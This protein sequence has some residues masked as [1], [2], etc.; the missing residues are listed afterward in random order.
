MDKLTDILYRIKQLDGGQFQNLCDAYLCYLGYESFHPFGMCTGTN[1]TAPGSP[2]TY[3]FVT[4]HNKYVLVMYTAQNTDFVNKTLKDFEKC[5]D[6]E[7]TGLSSN[8]DIAEIVYCHTYER[9]KPGDHQKLYNF[10]A[11]RHVK[12][13]L[14]GIETIGMDIYTKYPR[15]AKMLGVSLDTDQ[16]HTMEE[17]VSM[18]DANTMSAP[19]KTELLFRKQEL[20]DAK[21]KLNDSNILL[22]TGP[23][24]T[25][26]TRFALQLCEELS[27][28]NGYSVLCIKN[29]GQPIYEDLI[30]SLDN[31]KHYLVFV[32]DANELTQLNLVLSYLSKPNCSQH[33]DKLVLTVRDY[34]R[35]K[36]LEQVLEVDKPEIIKLQPFKRDEITKIVKNSYQITNIQYLN[37]IADIAQG[38]PRLAMLAGKLAL[39]SNSL[40]VIHNVSELYAN[41]YG[42][43]IKAIIQSETGIISA[44]IIAFLQAL[45]LD[46]IDVLTSLFSIANITKDQFISDLK[47]LH[48]QELV[49]IVHDNGVR[50]SDESFSNY[51]IKYVFIDK[52]I[53]RLS[54]MVETCLG[55]N[56]QRTI[57]ACNI[58]LNVLF[59]DEDAKTYTLDELNCVW[60]N[61]EKDSNR[62]PLFFEKFYMI[63]PTQTLIILRNQINQTVPT[64]YDV[65]TIDLINSD[66]NVPISD[67]IITKLCN[68]SDEPEVSTAIDLMLQYYQKRPDLFLQI[69]S[70]I[71]QYFNVNIHAQALNYFTQQAVIERLCHLIAQSPPYENA[72]LFVQ[73]ASS[74]LQFDIMSHESYDDRSIHCYTIHLQMNKT[75]SQYRNDLLSK[76]FEL[77]A[78]GICKEQIHKLLMEYCPNPRANVDYTLVENEFRSILKFLTIFST[79]SLYQCIIA[80]HLS[81]IAA[82]LNGIESDIFTPFLCAPKYKIYHTLTAS[83]DEFLESHRSK[84]STFQLRIEKFV[85]NYTLEQFEDIFEVCK[86]VLPIFHEVPIRLSRGISYAINA[87]SAQPQL[88]PQII[89]A[90]LIADIPYNIYPH[91]ILENLFSMMSAEEVKNL[92]T[93]VDYSQQNTW[94]WEFYVTLP[95]T[96]LSTTWSDDLLL[97]LQN[98]PLSLRQA[99]LRSIDLIQKYKCADPN[100]IS[101]ASRIILNHYDDSPFVFSLYFSNLLNSYHISPQKVIDLYN[102]HL[103][104]L[105]SIY[106]KCMLDLD[107]L[108]YDGDLLFEIMQQDPQFLHIYLDAY[109]NSAKQRA[110][111][112][113]QNSQIDCLRTHIWNANY[114]VYMDDISDYLY[115]NCVDYQYSFS[116]DHLLRYNDAESDIYHRQTQ[117]IEHTIQKYALD[118]RRMIALF[119]ALA[120]HQNADRTKTALKTFLEANPK[121]ELFKKLPLE[122]SFHTWSGS[123]IP[124]IQNRISFLSSLLPL[125]SGLDFLEHRQRIEELIKRWK[126]KIQQEEIN[127]LLSPWK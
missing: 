78:Q 3:F 122:P 38:N 69:H 104:L 62:F 57:S 75:L 67:S 18:H 91:D 77:Y 82:Y 119:R 49:D 74:F 76:L 46:C 106:L 27:A 73:I 66:H 71:T 59:T 52:K 118:E 2:D 53:I 48:E 9:L 125:L 85:Q 43:Q 68:F 56:E 33:I 47:L 123:Q 80:A 6:T 15:L 81:E 124:Y 60:S 42:P 90:Y 20:L 26:K 70:A 61:L 54:D 103:S 95:D 51:L 21:S 4:T 107:S 29:N 94:L 30:T 100:I 34:A 117:W 45:R 64:A 10:C 86:E 84:M 93:S 32:D 44:G 112:R 72:L 25:G 58:L 109:C 11:E 92:I 31:Q 1:K 97:Y 55:V 41:Y 87:F 79:D 39:Q 35:Q 105:E 50:I 96:Q 98:P 7:K 108:D 28:E 8:E 36:V 113:S 116:I 65:H 127:E 114:M 12:L 14:I 17:F 83:P 102:N 121:Y 111:S 99:P 16:I 88:Y 110:F 40:S 24:G 89:K 63:R 5:F 13:T 120:E 101:K 115:E 37:K 19:L 23:A 22:L 126:K